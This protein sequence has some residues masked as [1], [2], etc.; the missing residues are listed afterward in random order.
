MPR[1]EGGGDRRGDTGGEGDLHPPLRQPRPLAN[2]RTESTADLDGRSL[3]PRRTARPDDQGGAQQ[4]HAGNPGADPAALG[5]YGH[6]HVGNPCPSSFPRQEGHQQ[7]CHQCPG[8]GE[9]Q[10]VPGGEGREKAGQ[11]HEEEVSQQ[12][13]KPSKGDGSNTSHQSDGYGQD[14]QGEGALPSR[15]RGGAEAG[16]RQSFR[17]RTRA[18][19][20]SR[21][22]GRIPG[23]ATARPDRRAPT[24]VAGRPRSPSDPTLVE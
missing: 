2:C 10:K 17:R 13:E 19:G 15:P 22:P 3:D 23:S 14:G 21:T 9:Q 7:P 5:H 1:I 4:F 16:E 20:P 12:G 24:P 6:H 18:Y 11:G 8:G